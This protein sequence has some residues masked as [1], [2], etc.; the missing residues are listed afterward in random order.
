MNG[1]V[2]PSEVVAM[3]QAKETMQNQVT[4][5]GSETL[6][7]RLD[8]IL[9]DLKL[10]PFFYTKQCE[11]FHWRCA[12]IEKKNSNDNFDRKYLLSTNSFDQVLKMI[13]SPEQYSRNN[14][15]ARNKFSVQ[16]PL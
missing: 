7:I 1:N 12:Y 9:A 2:K 4:L 3:S 10:D 11:W 13:E 15:E 16:K 6:Y 5:V 8:L 14:L